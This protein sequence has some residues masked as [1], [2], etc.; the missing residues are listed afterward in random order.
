MAE[1]AERS[2]TAP[3]PIAHA[4]MSAGD[5]LNAAPRVQRLAATAVALNAGQA[6][7][8]LMPPKKDPSKEKKG[9]KKQ[10]KQK[11]AA[12]GTARA[13]NR[14]VE[15]LANSVQGYDTTKH[16]RKEIRAAIAAG[17]V[18]KMRAGHLSADSSQNMN[19]GTRKTIT[20]LTGAIKAEKAKAKAEEHKHAGSDVDGDEEDFELDVDYDDTGYKPPRDQDPPPPGAGG[21][22]G[23]A[24]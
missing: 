1:F 12:K 9:N 3:P 6:P 8:Q 11:A 2:R 13:K 21:A 16:S 20:G 19:A 17:N 10:E 4:P 14:K 15:R 5:A 18:N 22:E 7:I 23:I 24:V